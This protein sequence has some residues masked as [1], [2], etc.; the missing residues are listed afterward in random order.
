VERATGDDSATTLDEPSVEGHTVPTA[1]SGVRDGRRR[2]SL[3]PRERDV[4]VLVARG[5]NNRQIAR[6]LALSERTVEW[7]VGNVLHK[8][9][10]R[11]RLE[12][13]VWAF[14]RD[15]RG[16]T[17]APDVQAR[18]MGGAGARRALREGSHV[19]PGR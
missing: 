13:A 18:P 1:G 12:L 8:L 4:V 14:Q 2:S 5:S 16:V 11:S 9:A 15:V 3:T 10:V 6:E 19:D 7:H 17:A